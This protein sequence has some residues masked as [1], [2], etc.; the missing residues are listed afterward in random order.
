MTQRCRFCE[1]EHESCICAP[2]PEAKD[3]LRDGRA[4]QRRRCTCAL[5]RA[6]GCCCGKGP[7]ESSCMT[8]PPSRAN[9][10]PLDARALKARLEDRDVVIGVLRERCQRLESVLEAAREHL[11]HS[12]IV[13]TS[14]P[15]IEA[16]NR[17]EQVIAQADAPPKGAPRAD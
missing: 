11:L 4:A 10:H 17:L 2:G 13:S 14:R 15:Q 7:L 6:E 3:A 9:P 1:L 12:A 5:E 8:L 16:K